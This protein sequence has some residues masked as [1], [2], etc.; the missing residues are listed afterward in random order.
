LAGI[1]GK[2]TFWVSL[3]SLNESSVGKF[4]FRILRLKQGLGTTGFYNTIT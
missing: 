4:I 2:V 3:I 1:G